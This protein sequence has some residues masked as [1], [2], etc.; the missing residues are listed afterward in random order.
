MNEKQAKRLTWAILLLVPILP[1]YM[2]IA[3]LILKPVEAI[4]IFLLEYFAFQYLIAVFIK[5]LALRI[6]AER[7]RK[8]EESK[9]E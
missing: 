1:S 8:S 3:A 7:E 9:P 4:C 6:Q 2:V 5:R